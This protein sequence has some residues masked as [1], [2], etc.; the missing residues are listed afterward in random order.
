MRWIL[1]TMRISSDSWGM[2]RRSEARHEVEAEEGVEKYSAIMTEV[3]HSVS[4]SA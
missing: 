4:E 1:T 2:A 3:W